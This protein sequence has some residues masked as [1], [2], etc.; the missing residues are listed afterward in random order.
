[1]PVRFTL[2]GGILFA[3][4]FLTVLE[5]HAQDSLV[6]FRY[7]NGI[8][9]SEGFFKNGNPMATGSPTIKTES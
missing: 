9:S 4:T 5:V 6:T 2:S 7:P 8:I 1:M 3:V